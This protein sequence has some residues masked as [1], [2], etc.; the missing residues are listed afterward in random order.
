MH[1]RKKLNCDKISMNLYR[2]VL[3]TRPILS[4]SSLKELKYSN[5][6]IQNFETKLFFWQ[7]LNLQ[8][9]FAKIWDKLKHSPILIIIQAS[10]IL[11]VLIALSF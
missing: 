8:E 5:S 7:N 2:D 10:I 3:R 6:L 9:T 11:F 4:T 1:L